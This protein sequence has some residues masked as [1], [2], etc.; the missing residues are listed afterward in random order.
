MRSLLELE[1]A[2]TPEVGATGWHCCR[3]AQNECSE[4]DDAIQERLGWLPNQNVIAVKQGDDR[5]RRLFNTDYMIRIQEHRLSVK[6]GDQNHENLRNFVVTVANNSRRSSIFSWLADC[7]VRN[8][9]SIESIASKLMY[10][11][12]ILWM[13]SIFSVS[14]GPILETCSR[15]R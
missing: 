10:F 4:G 5:I 8:Q 1:I 3:T 12:A 9:S 14:S 6:P 11:S 13:S 15:K 2:P 7:M